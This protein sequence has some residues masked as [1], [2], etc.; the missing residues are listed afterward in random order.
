M[1]LLGLPHNF[2]DRNF[3]EHVKKAMSRKY[4]KG[5]LSLL[6][7][8]RLFRYKNR[9]RLFN[10]KGDDA[11]HEIIRF[12]ADTIDFEGLKGTFPPRG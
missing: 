9:L 1:K 2:H 10:L 4:P 11:W 3:E 12:K 7:A 5:Y 8:S 6:I